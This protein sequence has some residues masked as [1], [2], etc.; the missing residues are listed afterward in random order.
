MRGFT[1]E[2]LNLYFQSIDHFKCL[3]YVALHV[4]TR[5]ILRMHANIEENISKIIGGKVFRILVLMFNFT[6][7]NPL[8]NKLS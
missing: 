2:L 6:I 1:L 3:T 7:Y 8:E 4:F 5:H